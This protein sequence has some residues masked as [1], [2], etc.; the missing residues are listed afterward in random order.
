MCAV[1]AAS[2]AVS[3]VRGLVTVDRVLTAAL[4][5]GVVVFALASRRPSRFE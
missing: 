5:V 2:Y 3:S 4:L 1:A